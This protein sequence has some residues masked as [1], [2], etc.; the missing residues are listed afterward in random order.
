M[1]STVTTYRE[2]VERW[3]EANDPPM[4]RSRKDTDAEAA[5]MVAAI[6]PGMSWCEEA[7]KLI[8]PNGLDA[9]REKP[10]ERLEEVV[11]ETLSVRADW[12]SRRL[13]EAIEGGE[14]KS[15]VRAC[16][17]YRDKCFKAYSSAFITG[18]AKVFRKTRRI[19]ASD[20]N[21]EPSALGTPDGVA[22]LENGCLLRDIDE[23][24]RDWHVTKST[25]GRLES[26]FHSFRRDTRWDDFVLEIM[27][28]DEERADYLK[29]ALG[30]SAYGGNREECMF[31]AFGPTS[32]NGK[33]VLLESVAWALGDYASAVDHDYL[34]ERRNG[35]SGPDEET[36]SLDGVRLVTVSEPTRGKRMDEARVK[37]LTGGDSISCRH[38]FGRQFS[39][40]PQFT[41]WLSCNR[42]P[43]VDDTTVFTSGRIRVIP[44]ERHF[45]EAEQDK[46]LKRRFMS[47]RGS[48]TIMEWLFEGY[49]DYMRVG[50][51]EPASIKA[52]TANYALSGGSSLAKFVDSCCDFGAN[53]RM[54]VADFNAA[55]RAFCDDLGEVPVSPQKARREFE[56]MGV[57]KMKSN[58][59]RMYCGASLNVHGAELAAGGKGES[60]REKRPG[61]GHGEGNGPGTSGSGK[62][63]LS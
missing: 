34:M 37:A 20:L 47:Q 58:G 61:N 28:G 56:G 11:A 54:S 39:Y 31:V 32:R 22:D 10:P 52:S 49:Q 27:G 46:G 12:A 36:A 35:A 33:S 4:D 21:V 53:E 29:R 45:S 18:A 48:D 5:D 44:F 50:L 8:V 19:A 59:T 41:I 42:L 38:L 30:Y 15:A 60:H 23:D 63:K 7:Q 24:G 2:R 40:R 9:F 6:N 1:G 17:S 55:Y 62:V 43:I 14:G 13:E 25:V 51:S 26:G 3:L 57:T 16:A